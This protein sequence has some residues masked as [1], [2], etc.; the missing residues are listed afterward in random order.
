MI[1]EALKLLRSSIPRNIEMEW[2]IS[3]GCGPILGDPSQIHQIVMNLCT[4]AYHA[5]EER[6]GTVAIG[7]DEVEAVPRRSRIRRQGRGD[8]GSTAD[9]PRHPCA[10]GRPGSIRLVKSDG[11]TCWEKKK[12]VR[13]SVSDSGIG[14]EPSIMDRIFDPYFTTKEREKGSGLGLAVVHG[15]VQSHGGWICV[16]TEPGNGTTFEIYFPRSGGR[17]DMERRPGGDI[18]LSAGNEHVLIVDDEAPIAQMERILLERLGYRVTAFTESPK[19]LACFAAAPERFD[20]IITDQSMPRL[21]GDK[22]TKEVLSIRPD[23][24]VILCSGF[25]EKADEEGLLSLG[26]RKFIAKPVKVGQF[27][28]AVREVLNERV[29]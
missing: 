29:R 3:D 21:T 8:G 19:A 26:I 1:K 12:F 24:P 25:S 7:L 22:L 27:A 6:G 18:E 17:P 20:L 14:I 15:I 2:R 10:D 16:E 23:M 5:V 13:L 4:N 28:A 11:I 9:N